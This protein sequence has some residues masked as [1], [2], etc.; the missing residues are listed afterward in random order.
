MKELGDLIR[1]ARERKGV[2]LEQASAD[3]RIRR[4]YLDAIE[5][6]DFRIF[7]GT[8]YATGFLR[9][10]AS[11]LGLNSDE[12]LQTYHAISP[13]AG[14][15]IAPATTVGMERLRRR[16]RR[17]LMWSTVA[18][19]FVILGAYAIKSYNGSSAP[20][21]STFPRTP[22]TRPTASPSIPSLLPP[23]KNDRDA[24]QA[25]KTLVHAQ[26]VIRVRAR[27]TAWIRIVNDGHQIYWGA[28]LAG[29]S[30]KWRGHTLTLAT[31]RAPAFEVWVDGTRD[32]RVSKSH[33]KVRLVAGPYTWHRTR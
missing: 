7:P 22:S 4:A 31:H 21:A 1:S 28:V 29:T 16:S 20:T 30:R 17:K 18:V 26:A 25:P 6:G 2:T 13:P 24:D 14:I 9:N 10:Y 32:W 15:S 8:A 3:T 33:G 12:I 19:L 23:G 5:D 11:Y 27:Q